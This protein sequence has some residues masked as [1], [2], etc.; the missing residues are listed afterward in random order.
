MVAA[1]KSTVPAAD[2]IVSQLEALGV[3]VVFGIPGVHNLA[4]F[5]SLR[6]SKIRTIVTRHEQASAYAADGYA[7]ATGRL[8][9]CISTTG[10]GVANTAAA[11]GEARASRSPVLHIGTQ[12]DVRTLSGKSGRGALHEN[13]DQLAL[14]G[15][16]TVSA[17]RA[18]TVTEIEPT[19]ARAIRAALSGRRGPVFVEIP[20]DLLSEAVTPPPRLPPKPASPKRPE[21]AALKKAA[22]VLNRARRP[23][24]W[25]GGGV[26]SAEAWN[27][28]VSV[29][30]SLDAPVVTTFSGKG[31]IPPDHPLCLGFPPHQ[32][33]VAELLERADALLVAGSDL[34]GMSTQGWRAPLP[35]PRVNINVVGDDARRNYAADIVLEADAK[36]ALQELLDR[37]K[38]HNNGGEGRVAAVRAAATAALTADK[39]FAPPYRFVQRLAAAVPPDAMLV[40]DMTIPGYWCAGYFPV[41]QPRGF[42]YPL[43]WGTLGF[44]FPAS[45]GVAASGRRAVVISGDGG[46]LFAPGELATAVQERLPVTVVVVNDGGYG[47][48]RFD[49][50]ERFGKR[51]GVDLVAPDYVEMA[52]S[53]GARARMSTPAKI[54]EALGWAV[55]QR[56]PTLIEVRVA[57]APPLTTSPRWP[58]KG[59]PEARP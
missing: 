26:H 30:E 16:V 3:E 48:L 4:I 53:F 1:R 20:F 32:P 39:A 58:L 17:S 8:G 22:S 55:R 54:G 38:P 47:M 37:L 23:V 24:V 35:R 49:Q 59:K 36:V 12:L 21:E 28:L 45:I 34:D 13:P 51:F 7:R 56:G 27:E 11:M 31:V 29:A 2:A 43:G 52:R 46:F 5:D 10:P 18:H 15:A 41:A 57:F 44:A 9:V 40:A 14:M 25:A 42:A 6:R 33:E 19:I 50:D